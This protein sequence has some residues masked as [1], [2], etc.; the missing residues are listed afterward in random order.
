MVTARPVTRRGVVDAVLV[1]ALATPGRVRV[2]VD[3]PVPNDRHTLADEIAAAFE[4]A[5]VASARVS[6]ADFLRPRSVRL[7]WGGSD[8]D[9]GYERWVDHDG[10]RREVLD[11]FRATGR[12][13][14]TLWDAQRDRATRAAPRTSPERAVLVLDGP[15]LL[16]WE[17]FGCLDQV[18]HLQTGVAAIERR[19]AAGEGPR[20]AGAWNRYLREIDPATRILAG[21][22]G[23]VVR[24]GHPDRPAIVTG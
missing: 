6:A 4:T 17:L 20:S 18:V 15:H 5:G 3:G 23:L 22:P 1:A 12:W 24:F 13:L 19:C 21:E 10:L 2:G 8:P 9:A 7:E 16:R 11:P 14:P